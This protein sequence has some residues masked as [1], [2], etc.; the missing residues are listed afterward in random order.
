MPFLYLYTL[1]ER[2][3]NNAYGYVLLSIY[4]RIMDSLC[5][6]GWGIETERRLFD[7]LFG[8]NKPSFTI[9]KVRNDRD[10][11][12]GSVRLNITI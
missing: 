7:V 2:L 12:E 1:S 8:F 10:G 6:Y 4:T 3:N 11:L 9:F 5:T